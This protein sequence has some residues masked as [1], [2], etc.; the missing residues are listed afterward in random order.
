MLLCEVVTVCV[1]HLSCNV[2]NGLLCWMS[3]CC[4]NA[5]FCGVVSCCVA[6][7]CMCV[8]GGSYCIKTFFTDAD[9]VDAVC[10]S[11]RH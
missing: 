9:V 6:R 11:A 10:R 2:V 5:C 4:C 1:L 8:L 3:S 7:A